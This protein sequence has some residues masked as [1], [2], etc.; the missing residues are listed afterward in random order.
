[1]ALAPR[2]EVTSRC[3]YRLD[4]P[5]DESDALSRCSDMNCLGQCR[6]FAAAMLLTGCAASTEVVAD[7][8]PAMANALAGS[9][10]PPSGIGGVIDPSA[11]TD[12]VGLL[13]PRSD[14]CEAAVTPTA[15]APPR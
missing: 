5:G 8:E 14:Q 3:A 12:W 4:V 2:F 9:P 11:P 1:M 6:W 7:G 13:K 10:G 15:P